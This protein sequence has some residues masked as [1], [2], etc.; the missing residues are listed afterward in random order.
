MCVIPEA[1]LHKNGITTKNR[2]DPERLNQKFSRFLI[3]TSYYGFNSNV[4]KVKSNVLKTVQY[5]KKHL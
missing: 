5:I 2:S 1:S 3:K 4:N